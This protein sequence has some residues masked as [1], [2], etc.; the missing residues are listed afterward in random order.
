MFGQGST[1]IERL[2]KVD[3]KLRSS[4]KDA[5]EIINSAR[6]NG[7]KFHEATNFVAAVGMLVNNIDYEHKRDIRK[8]NMKMSIMGKMTTQTEYLLQFENIL[9]KNRSPR[10]KLVR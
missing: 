7:R 2:L 10:L 6:M 8:L 1:R 9:N 3:Y 5:I 4:W